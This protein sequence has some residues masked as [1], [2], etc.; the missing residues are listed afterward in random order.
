MRRGLFEEIGLPGLRPAFL[1]TREQIDYGPLPFWWPV[2]SLRDN[3]R[4]A[5]HFAPFERFGPDESGEL[6]G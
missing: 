6:F 4:S 1:D 2:I 3:P 5:H